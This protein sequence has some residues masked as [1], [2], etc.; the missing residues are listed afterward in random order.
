ML[1]L[2]LWVSDS[3]HCPAAPCLCCRLAIGLQHEVEHIFMEYS[4]GVAGMRLM[5][6]LWRL[7]VV[8]QG[9]LWPCRQVY[10]PCTCCRGAA[11]MR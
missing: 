3:P 11:L 2:M 9:L 5:P 10:M 8:V 6:W 7:H 1:M 4:P